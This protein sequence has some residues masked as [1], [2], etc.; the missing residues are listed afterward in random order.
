MAEPYELSASELGEHYR[1]RS[2]S[3]VEATRSVLARIERWEP[4]LKATYALDPE[5]A[6]EA[7]RASEG[8]WRR[9]ESFGPLDGVPATLKENIPTR[10]A[11]VPL[12]TAATELVPAAADSPPAARL[13]EA[14]VVI[15]GKTTMP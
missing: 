14:G 8:R 4:R 6:L 2:L 5:G 1:R 3:P 13:R 10:G 7:A 15:L 11:P 9:G 12:G